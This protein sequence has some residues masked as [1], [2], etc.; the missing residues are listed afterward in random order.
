MN[1]ESQ[2]DKKKWTQT[3]QYNNNLYNNL[4]L[5]IICIIPRFTDNLHL[6]HVMSQALGKG[7]LL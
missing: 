1:V 5:N 7:V 2:D 4:Y 3:I 6:H